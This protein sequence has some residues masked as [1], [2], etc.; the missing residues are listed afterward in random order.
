MRRVVLDY[1]E[2]MLKTENSIL[3]ITNNVSMS[4]NDLSAVVVD[5]LGGPMKGMAEEVSLYRL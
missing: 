3:N 1:E 2:I 4:A 5:Q